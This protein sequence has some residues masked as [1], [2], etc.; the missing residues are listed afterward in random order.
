[1]EI[2][3]RPDVKLDAIAPVHRNVSQDAHFVFWEKQHQLFHQKL[4]R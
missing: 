2:R 1:M 4:L 3:N